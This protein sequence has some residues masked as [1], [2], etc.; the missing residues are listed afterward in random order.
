MQHPVQFKGSAL[1]RR[2]LGLAGWRVTFNGLPALQG[3]IV[4]YPHTSN[5]D[6]IVGILAKWAI[7]IPAHF[8]AKD[9]LFRLPVFGRWLRWVGGLPIDRSGARG[10]VGQTVDTLHEHAQTHRLLWL[11]A[12]PEG[13]RKWTPGW[14]S[15]FYQVALGAGVPVG[16]VRL[17]W[18]RREIRFVDFLTLSG[19]EAQDYAR[20]AAAFDGVRGYHPEQASPIVPWRPTKDRK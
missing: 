19:E 10:A 8:W 15:G 12:A 6:F 5:W 14:R 4:A 11:A 16:I 13:T 3:V 20:L 9:S 7:G 2:L 1:A 18:G 17:D